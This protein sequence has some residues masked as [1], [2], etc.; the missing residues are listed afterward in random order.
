MIFRIPR[1]AAAFM[2]LVTTFGLLVLIVAV[3]WT[4]L[5]LT[6]RY[7]NRL[8]DASV[9]NSAD[10]GTR[11]HAGRLL[12]AGTDGMFHLNGRPKRLISGEFHYFRIHPAQW[13]D[14]LRRMRT[15]GL[16]TITTRV[17]WNFHERR[18]STIQFR[19]M[20][21]LADFM[22]VVHRLGFLLIVHVGPYIDADWELGGLPSWLLRDPHMTLRTSSYP[23]FLQYVRRY[24]E[25]LLPIIERSTY[26]RRGPVIALQVENEFGS[27]GHE[28]T[29]YLQELVRLVRSHGI[30]ELILTADR[31]PHLREGSVP[32]T[33]A[34]VTCHGSV[35]EVGAALSSLSSFQPGLPRLVTLLDGNGTSRWGEVRP[36]RAANSVENF[37]RSVDLVLRF[38][39]SINVYAFSGGTNFGLWNGAVEHSGT[40]GASISLVQQAVRR[41]GRHRHRF[42]HWKQHQ[43]RNNNNVPAAELSLINQTIWTTLGPADQTAGLVYRPATTAYNYSPP[44]LMSQSGQSQFS[45]KFHAFRRLLLNRHLISRLQAVPADPAISA[46]GVVRLDHQLAWQKLL[47]LIPSSPITLDSPVFMEQ[48]NTQLGSGQ[49]HGWIVYRT[50]LPRGG[51]QLNVSGTARDRIQLFINGRHLQTAYIN[52]LSS[53]NLVATF[54]SS[55]HRTNN[56]STPAHSILELVVE[57]M[58]RSSFGLLDDQRKGFEG[59]VSVDGKRLEAH[60]EHFS[61]DFSTALL[62]AVRESKDWT[63]TVRPSKFPQGQPTL[64][65]GHFKVRSMK[66]TYIDMTMWTKGVV[67]VN[68]FVLGRYWNIGPQ[69]SLYVPSPILSVH[70]VNELLVFEL[71]RTLNAKVKFVGKPAWN[72]HKHR[73]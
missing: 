33:L 14:R 42:K 46:I 43:R 35:E 50:R 45:L 51:S 16:N 25:H 36:V 21:N 38:N 15:A 13:E 19:G 64:Y 72:N 54:H 9:Y 48:L 53:F 55:F 66:D 12:S 60:W 28:D 20:W 67:V 17:P 47:E 59:S 24:F 34:T 65:R 70:G 30:E 3:A 62:A 2:R 23:P 4:S 18:Q 32:G 68:G 29:D 26:R 49:D 8:M 27:Y 56:H 39:A 73:G 10:N 40:D 11:K 41:R 57:N 5:F 44:P 58:G 61:I 22:R 63:P 37:R 6:V 7:T 31:G 52:T 71:E 1:M 69:Q